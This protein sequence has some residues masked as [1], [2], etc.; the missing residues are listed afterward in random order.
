MSFEFICFLARAEVVGRLAALSFAN[1]NANANGHQA[2]LVYPSNLT[3]AYAPNALGQPTQVGTFA[4][5]VSYYPNGAIKQFTYGNGIVHTLAQNARG[6]PIR[7]S[8]CAVAGTCAAATRRLDL[9]YTY[10]RHRNVQQIVDHVN[11]RQTRCMSYDA[12]ERLVQTTSNSSARPAM[13]TTCCT[14]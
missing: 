4:T 10:D 12:L 7:S 14:I 11:G 6:L 2:S 1:A 9:Q 3:V 13:H 5:G 8:D